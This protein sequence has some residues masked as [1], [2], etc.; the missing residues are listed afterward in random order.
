MQKLLVI[1]DEEAMR[2]L[3]RLNLSDIYEIIDTGDPELRQ[4]TP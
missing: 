4:G 3:L 1:D 2:R